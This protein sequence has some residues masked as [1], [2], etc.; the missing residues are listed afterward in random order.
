MFVVD[1][2]LVVFVMWLVVMCLGVVGGFVECC[3]GVL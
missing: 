1:V 2:G 3:V